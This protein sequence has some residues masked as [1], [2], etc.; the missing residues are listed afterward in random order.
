MNTQKTPLVQKLILFMLVLIFGCL[1]AVLINSRKQIETLRG[2]STGV[3]G[4]ADAPDDVRGVRSF[5]KLRSS[6][7]TQPT[8]TER[9]KPEVSPAP[10]VPPAPS[11]PETPASSVVAVP[12]AGGAAVVELPSVEA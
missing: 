7:N 6:R 1:V 12:V 9:P 8:S 11:P 4:A 5:P 10:V 3:N 2:N